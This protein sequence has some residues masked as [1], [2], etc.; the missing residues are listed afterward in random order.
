[1][2]TMTPWIDF[3]VAGFTLPG[4][5]ESGDRHLIH[6]NKQGVLVAVLDG[7]GHGEEAAK[8]AKAGISILETHSN[9]P[10]IQLVEDCHD[11]LRGT[12]GVALSL[13]FIHGPRRTMTWL[14]IGNIQGMLLR[15]I[16]STDVPAQ[17]TLLLRG[18][19]VGVVLPPLRSA[20]LSVASGDTLIFATDGLRPEFVEGLRPNE[21]PQ[22]MADDVLLRYRNEKDDALVL[23]ARVNGFQK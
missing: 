7:V 4:Q 21:T 11:G 3:G 16:R 9:E 17:E 1:M 2:E 5:G 13:A 23:V 22:R 8:A 18:G 6:A 15:G 19:T 12:R 10:I 14:G 20:E